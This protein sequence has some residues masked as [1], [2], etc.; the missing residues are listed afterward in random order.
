MNKDRT[1]YESEYFPIKMRATCLDLVNVKVYT[2]RNFI[3][4]DRLISF[5]NEYQGISSVSAF[6][7][8]IL[9]SVILTSIKSFKQAKIELDEIEGTIECVLTNPLAI[10]PVVGYDRIPSFES[11]VIKLYYYANERHETCVDCITRAQLYN[12]VY[13]MVKK[14]T[15]VDLKINKTL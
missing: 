9:S 2:D 8:S 3:S 13:N 11:I 5:D 10:I 1:P 12:P 14:A 15:Q 4:T 6:L 7:S